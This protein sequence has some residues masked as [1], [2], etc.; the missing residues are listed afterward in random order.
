MKW[1]LTI[2][3]QVKENFSF[4]KY[5]DSGLCDIV[6]MEA[7]SI[8]LGRSWQFDKKTMHN[9]LTNEI[10]FTHKEKK[11]VLHHLAHPQVFEDKVRLKKR[12][13]EMRRE[14]RIKK[15][16]KLSKT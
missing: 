7:C 4:G 13:R 12:K 10:T 5:E 2:N 1:D 16:L 8:V 9:G 11:F 6:S 15:A 14:K 3:Q